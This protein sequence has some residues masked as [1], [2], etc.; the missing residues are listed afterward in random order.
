MSFTN[1][2]WAINAPVKFSAKELLGPWA[3]EAA[4]NAAEHS[5]AF[6]DAV[7][8]ASTSE[9]RTHAAIYD[10]EASLG[11]DELIPKP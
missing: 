7:F 11:R 10:A 6:D 4:A 1:A 8:D 2:N 5:A 3:A 9:M